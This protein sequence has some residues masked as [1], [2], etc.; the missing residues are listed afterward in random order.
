M[1]MRRED[2]LTHASQ[3]NLPLASGLGDDLSAYRDGVRR[4]V[5]YLAERQIEAIGYGAVIQQRRTGAGGVLRHDDVRAGS[6]SASRHI[7]RAFEAADILADPGAPPVAARTCVIPAEARIDGTFIPADAG[8]TQGKAELR[9]TEGLGIAADLDPVMTEIVLAATGG[10]DVRGA[11]DAAADRLGLSDQERADL[12]A[13]AVAM[14]SQLVGL[15]L[16]EFA[17]R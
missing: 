1:L 8:W 17:P 10:V 16:L 7:V 13:S 3:W 9:L 5:D 6:G 12:R 15:G 14:I 4:W 2:P 11:A